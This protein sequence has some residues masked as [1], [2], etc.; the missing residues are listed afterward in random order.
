M[1]RE[2]TGSS[3]MRKLAIAALWAVVLTILGRWILSEDSDKW[4]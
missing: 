4:T 1:A 3:D 2:V